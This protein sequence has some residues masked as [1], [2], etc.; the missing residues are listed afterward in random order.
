MDSR[1]V[2]AATAWILAILGL[3]LMGITV[4]TTFWF[5]VNFS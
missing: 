1:K 2:S 5:M 3:A 4:F